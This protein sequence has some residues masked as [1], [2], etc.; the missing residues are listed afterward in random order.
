MFLLFT[1]ILNIV[2]TFAFNTT[3]SNETNSDSSSTFLDL[4]QENLTIVIIVAAAILLLLMLFFIL[5]CVCC[6]KNKR[7]HDP[8]KHS[9]QQFELPS[10]PTSQ[11]KDFGNFLQK[12]QVQ[13]E[14]PQTTQENDRLTDSDALRTL[15]LEQYNRNENS[16]S[17]DEFT[18]GII[19]A[20]PE[21]WAIDFAEIT[22]STM[23]GEGSYGKNQLFS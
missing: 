20:T 23:L 15:Q 5:L 10:I 1:L 6:L 16:E 22:M 21:W 12:V 13:A 11:S 3:S 9:S 7:K 8:F 2:G 19:A 14:T 4:L 17:F 18:N